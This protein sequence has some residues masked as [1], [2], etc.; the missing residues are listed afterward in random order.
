M[1]KRLF[2]ALEPPQSCRKTLAGL[3]PGVKG[4]RWLSA[5]L[6]HL[7]LSFLGDVE[8]GDEERLRRALEEVEV[9]AFFLPD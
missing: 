6:M 1:S 5:E 2:V 8:G 9:P 3:D 4:V 7:T